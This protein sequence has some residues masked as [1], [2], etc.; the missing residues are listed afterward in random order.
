MQADR[1][2]NYS[3]SISDQSVD[4]IQIQTPTT[5]NIGKAYLNALTHLKFPKIEA[6]ELA[7]SKA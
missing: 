2:F 3:C 4:H 7:L 6:S 5:G 1:N